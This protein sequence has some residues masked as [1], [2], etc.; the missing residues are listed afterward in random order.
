MLSPLP[1]EVIM[2]IR[3]PTGFSSGFLSLQSP[4]AI[5]EYC[6]SHSQGPY[7]TNNSANLETQTLARG[8]NGLTA[9]RDTS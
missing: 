1:I 8:L 2:A 5:Y 9:N 3:A 7:D 6:I 4:E